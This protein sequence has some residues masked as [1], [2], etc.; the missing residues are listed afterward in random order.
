MRPSNPPAPTQPPRRHPRYT[1]P[2]TALIVAAVIPAVAFYVII[3]DVK[4]RFTR[5][6]LRELGAPFEIVLTVKFAEG[7][8]E[9]R[10]E[11]VGIEV[12]RAIGLEG[13]GEGG[14]G[15]ERVV[16]REGAEGGGVEKAEGAAP[17][18]E[19]EAETNVGDTGPTRETGEETRSAKAGGVV[20]RAAVVGY[21][22]R[23]GAD[24][25]ADAVRGKVLRTTTFGKCEVVEAE[26]R[27]AREEMEEE[28]E[29][30]KVEG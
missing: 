17:G 28:M 20:V 4:K 29:E 5:E 18:S 12:G 13:G 22:G 26:V 7:G 14:E 2:L 8:V 10:W 19:R 24:K 25:V 27:E 9:G 3:P 16:V 23:I 15:R 6:F 21:V 1:N 11:E 30:E